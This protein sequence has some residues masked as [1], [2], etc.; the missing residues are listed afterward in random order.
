[1]VRRRTLLESSKKR[2]MI[3]LVE[4]M[5][6]KRVSDGISHMD[7]RHKTL[8]FSIKIFVK[9]PPSVGLRISIYIDVYKIK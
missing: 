8:E 5:R 3:L 9:P 7:G 6:R 2:T 1:M 4:K